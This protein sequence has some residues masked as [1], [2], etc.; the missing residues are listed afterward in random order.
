VKDT[1]KVIRIPREYRVGLLFFLLGCCAYAAIHLHHFRSHT[2]QR[3]E[4][5]SFGLIGFGLG[6]LSFA[7]ALRRNRERK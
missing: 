3:I 6:Q 5:A 7:W 1:R 2:E 4:V